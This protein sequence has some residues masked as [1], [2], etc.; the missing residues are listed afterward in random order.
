MN[1]VIVSGATGAIG[2]ALITK[3]IEREIEVLV[4]THKGSARNETI[5]KHELVTTMDATL[6]ALDDIRNDS[7]KRYDTFFHLAWAGTT[8]ASRNDAC[9]QSSNIRYSLDAVKLAERFGCETFV[10]IGSQAEYGRYEGL[11]K[12]DSLVN[13]ETCYGIAKLAAGMLTRELA[14]QLGIRHI[15]VRVVSIY[16]PQDG[17]DTMVMSMISKLRKGEP[18]KLTKGEQM[19][20]YLYSGD[21]AEAL[22][23]LGSKGMDGKTY[24]LGSGQAQ[25][26]RWY[27][28][29]IRDAVDPD[30]AMEIGAIPYA[31]RQVM[32]LCADISELTEDTGWRPKTPFSEG[33][34]SLL[35]VC[36]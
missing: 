12:A 10:G 2:N 4:L 28:E 24:V 7:G 20:D 31:E 3:L 5:P 30:A 32:F 34:Q 27:F 29:Q 15:W 11:L 13:P 22:V 8:G 18:P 21:A 1:R 23:R 35:R 9:L 19:W 33:I 36:Q 26:L 17:P 25:P 6:S 16:G 14:G